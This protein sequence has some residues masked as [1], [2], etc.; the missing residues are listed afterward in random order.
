M[1]T[2]KDTKSKAK[3]RLNP[4]IKLEKHLGKQIYEALQGSV[5]EAVLRKIKTSSSD[6]YWRSSMEGHSLKVQQDLLPD[7]YALCQ[8]VKEKLNFDEPVDFYIT[9]DSSVNAF[10]VAAEDEGEPNIVLSP[11][12]ECHKS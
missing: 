6:A 3:I 11:K 4:S 12:A 5:V 10:S 9:G 8:E 1:A 7:F 2:R